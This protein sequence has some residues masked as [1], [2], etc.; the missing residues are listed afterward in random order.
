M[1]PSQFNENRNYK[2]PKIHP[3]IAASRWN[4][5]EKKVIPR[6]TV[7]LPI[8]SDLQSDAYHEP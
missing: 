1:N 3:L 6:I 4:S 8:G 2:V 7:N 5:L